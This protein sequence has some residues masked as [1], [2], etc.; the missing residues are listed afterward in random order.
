MF[1]LRS[2]SLGLESCNMQ[3]V[4]N[5]SDDNAILLPGRIPGYKSSNVQ[6]LPSNTTKIAVWSAYQVN[7]QLL[8]CST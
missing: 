7:G 6:L 3:R 5:Y 4:K 1:F 8:L 2:L